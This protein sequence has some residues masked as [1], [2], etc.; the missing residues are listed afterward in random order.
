MNQKSLHVKAVPVVAVAVLLSS[1][2]FAADLSKKVEK[3]VRQSITTRQKT[4][5]GVE[6]WQQD[7]ADLNARFDALKEE[8][9]EMTVYRDK[10]RKRVDAGRRRLAAKREQLAE[11]AKISEE[12]TPFLDEI[13][14][15]L[16]EVTADG[17]PFLEKERRGRLAR[18]KEM[19]ADPQISIGEKYRRLMEALQIEAEYGLTAEVYQQEIETETE[20][21]LVNVVRLGRL[22]L[23]YLGLD[24]RSC[25]L[26]NEAAGRWEKLDDSWLRNLASVVAMI[27]REEPVGMV[28]LPIGA[29]KR[30]AQ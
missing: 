24:G 7:R 3:P 8:T 17:P 28:A 18:M 11:T 30:E 23:F 27:R 26:W 16:G 10:L 22:N 9:A 5:Q 12:I 2:V 25:G 13:L 20:P 15:L 6:K 4:Q 19:M 29:I 21:L 1:S 14:T